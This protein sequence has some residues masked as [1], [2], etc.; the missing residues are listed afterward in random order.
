MSKKGALKF[1][2]PLFDFFFFFFQ[3]SSAGNLAVK[4]NKIKL[5][6]FDVILFLE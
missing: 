6:E 3:K 4:K 2:T 1:L 5:V